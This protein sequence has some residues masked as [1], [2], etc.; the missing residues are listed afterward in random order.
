M[1]ENTVSMSKKA[2]TE[3]SGPKNTAGA[4]YGPREEA[5]RRSNRLRREHDRQTA[6]EGRS[7]LDSPVTPEEPIRLAVDYTRIGIPASTCWRGSRRI[8]RPRRRELASR[9]TPAALRLNPE[10]ASGRDRR[11]S[12]R[13]PKLGRANHRLAGSLARKRPDL[14]GGLRREQPLHFKCRG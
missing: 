11:E 1:T 6:D 7:D 5:K 14:G 12:A 4:F 10:T 2:K 9:H 13:A 3:H 8:R